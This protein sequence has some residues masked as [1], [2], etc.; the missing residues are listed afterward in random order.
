MRRPAAAI[1]IEEEVMEFKPGILDKIA[2][3]K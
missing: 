3:V 2:A 1:G